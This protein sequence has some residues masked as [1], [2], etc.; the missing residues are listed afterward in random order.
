MVWG[1][2]GQSKGPRFTRSWQ[3][4]SCGSADNKPHWK[5]CGGCNT[6]WETRA[7][8]PERTQTAPQQNRWAQGPPS[9]TVAKVATPPKVPP[10]SGAAAEVGTKSPAPT[11]TRRDGDPSSD[12]AQEANAEIGKAKADLANVQ[13]SIK[14]LST[15]SGMEDVI[16]QLMHREDFLLSY[17]AEITPKPPSTVMAQRHLRKIEH[18]SQVLL[19]VKRHIKDTSKQ[20]REFKE[21]YI[22]R[23]AEILELRAQWESLDTN[24]GDSPSDMPAEGDWADEDDEDPAQTGPDV[25]S[26]KEGDVEM[27]EKQGNFKVLDKGAQHH[28]VHPGWA[29][30]REAHP[31]RGGTHQCPKQNKGLKPHHKY[32][33]RHTLQPLERPSLLRQAQRTLRA[34]IPPKDPGA[35]CLP[36]NQYVR[37]IRAAA[38]LTTTHPAVFW[39]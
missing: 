27:G 35:D 3:C 1:T 29:P 18:I 21:D 8:S 37:G 10:V 13:S 34:G 2:K 6:H 9:I 38:I 36:R 14:T 39:C 17:L 22:N 25:I 32:A 23:R 7:Y 26:D 20:L 4:Y 30:T 28:R 33:A 12:P 5:W 31:T 16:V 15:Q 24:L 11:A 19:K